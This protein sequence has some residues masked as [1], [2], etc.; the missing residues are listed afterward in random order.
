MR[1][2]IKDINETQNT[3]VNFPIIAD[4]NKEIARILPRAGTLVTFLSE[5]VPHEVLP[6]ARERASIA[7]WFRCNTSTSA[8]IDPLR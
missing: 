1:D 3:T 2:E 7:G 8:S 5:D 6:P 4:E